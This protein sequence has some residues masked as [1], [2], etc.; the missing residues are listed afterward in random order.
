MTPANGLTPGE[1]ITIVNRFIGVS[2]GYLGDFS[3]RSHDEFYA[4][5]CDLPNIHPGDDQYTGT[6]RERF[7][8]IL[9]SRPPREQASIIRG[10]VEK[11]GTT[12]EAE[13]GSLQSQLL[14]WASRLDGASP[15]AV[16]SPSETR[17]V[18]LR[19]LDDADTL[20]RSSGPTS[21][22]D[23]VHTALHGHLIALCESNSFEMPSEPTL[24]Q[25][26]RVLRTNHPA[27]QPTGPRAEDITRVL[28]STAVIL[29]ALNP[30]R[31]RASV[32][33]PN[34]E[35]LDDAEA[36]LAVNATRTIF[37]FLDSKLRG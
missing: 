16:D 9:S 34:A 3:Y 28:Q 24:A 17:A 35:L 13:A 32:A 10:V 36:M 26:L 8:Q 20:I 22:V 18:V 29:D 12:G 15:I 37:A 14:A 11:F 23:R 33:H 25:L 7:I 2:G 19:A 31:N 6:T 4:E 30:L 27:L 21:A 5:Y 1:V